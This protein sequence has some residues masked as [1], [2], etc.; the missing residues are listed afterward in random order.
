MGSIPSL[1]LS[2]STMP[3]PWLP[4]FP[5]KTFPA[6]LSSS[7]S[8]QAISLWSTAVLVLELL[9][10]LYS[11]SPVTMHSGGRASPSRVCRAMAQVVCVILTPFRWLQ[12]TF[13][14]QQP[15]MLPFCPNQLPW[16]GDLNPGSTPQPPRY[17]LVLFTIFLCFPSFLHSTKFCVDLCIPFRWSGTPASSQLI[18]LQDLLHVKMYSW[19]IH[20]ERCTPLPP[21]SLPCLPWAL[22]KNVS[23]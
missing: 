18:A 10:N 3:P 14:V 15:Q 2:S 4:G 22:F 6:T 8:P 20:G 17:R 5:P 19:C 13:P 9:S 11:P 16:C 12:I 1:W 7:S 23:V 21:T